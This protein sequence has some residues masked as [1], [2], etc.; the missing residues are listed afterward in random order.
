MLFRN[1]SVSE[2]G[3]GLTKVF[4]VVERKVALSGAKDSLLISQEGNQMDRVDAFPIVATKLWHF[5]M[6]FAHVR[7]AC[8]VQ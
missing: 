4:V 8:L 5:V 7:A 6:L 2:H 3:D 1:L